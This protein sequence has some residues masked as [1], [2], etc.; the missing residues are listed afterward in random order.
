MFLTNLSYTSSFIAVDNN[1]EKLVLRDIESLTETLKALSKDKK[2]IFCL[3]ENSIGALAGYL[4]FIRTKWVPIMLDARKDYTLLGNLLDIY[5][6]DYIWLP[7]RQKDIFGELTEVCHFNTYSLL[8]TRYSTDPR[9]LFKDLALLLTTSGSTGSPKLVRLSYA[10]LE[11]NA[12]SIATYLKIDKKEKP[13]TSLPMHYSYG[14]SVINSHL[15]K[16]ATILL[17]DKPVIQKE[18]WAFVEAQKATSLSGVPYT[19]EMLQRLRI[20]QMDL[21]ELK[22]LTQAGGK[23]NATLA[24]EYIDQAK[25]SQK[26]FIIM[27]GQTEATARMSYLPWDKAAEKYSSIGIAIPGGYFILIDEQGNEILDPDKEGELVYSGANVSLGYAECKEDLVKGDD[28]KGFLRTGDIAYRDKDGFYYVTGRLKRFVKIFGNRV[29]LDAIEQ[30][31]KVITPICACIGIDDKITVF[32]TEVNRENEIKN[33]LVQKTGL[34][35]RAFSVS[36]IA[37]IPKNSS[38]KIQYAELS[39]LLQ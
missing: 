25:A 33:M 30:L 11:N 13:V 38:G 27:Y 16:G 35:G 4:S 39:K 5:K 1:G 8:K 12:K 9:D 18:F 28:N 26:N 2:L 19:Y 29:N 23:L 6:P 10:N 3:C 36:V 34:N 21:P 31:V 14:L 22:T 37:N 32:V 7:E 20:F 15:I 24:K 17:T